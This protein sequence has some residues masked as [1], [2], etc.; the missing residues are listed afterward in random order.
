MA[1][2]DIYTIVLICW[3]TFWPKIKQKWPKIGRQKLK[4]A[5]FLLTR[6]R[7]FRRSRRWILTIMN[8]KFIRKTYLKIVGGWILWSFLYGFVVQI[9]VNWDSF[10]CL[11]WLVRIYFKPKKSAFFL[12]RKS[13]HFFKQENWF[14]IMRTRFK[15]NADFL[16]I[17][18]TALKIMRTLA[19]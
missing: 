1:E 16:K 18:R 5:L 4:G 13:P 10:N 7:S 15:K 8:L 6:L 2:A 14:K 3:I 17:M 11:R 9:L 12:N 19:V